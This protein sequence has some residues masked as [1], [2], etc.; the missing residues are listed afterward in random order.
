MVAAAGALLLG[1]LPAAVLGVAGVDRRGP[2]LRA[3]FPYAPILWGFVLA[4][5]CLP[6]QVYAYAWGLVTAPNGPLAPLTKMGAVLPAATNSGP[7]SGPYRIWIGSTIRAGLISAGWLWPVVA[8]ILAAGW[9]SAG[10][11][12]YALAVL[13][14]SPGKAFLRAVVPSLRAHLVAA[15]SI[16]FAITLIEYP[17][18][19]LSLARVYATEL[20]VLVDVGAPPGQVMGMG[21]QVIGIVLVLLAVAVWSVR[22]LASW[23]GLSDADEVSGSRG[24]VSWLVGVGAAMVWLLTL[25]LPVA[26]M[27]LSLRISGAWREGFKLFQ[28]EWAVSLGVSFIVALMAVAVAIA[29]AV[30]GTAVW[31]R[32]YPSSRPHPGVPGWGTLLISAPRWFMRSVPRFGAILALV[33]ALMPAAALGIGFVLIFNRAGIVG[34]LYTDTPVV[35][36]LALTARYA[37]VVVLIAWLALRKRGVEAAEQARTDGAGDWAVLSYVLLP[38][39]GPSLLAGGVIVAI[40]SLF[41]VVVSQ[42]IRP[43]GY[44]SIALALLNQMHY[45]RDDLVIITSL[46]IVTA[47]VIVTQLCGGLLV[48]R[49]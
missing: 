14:T 31:S 42:L 3:R 2:S 29:T 44:P 19:H 48:R 22:G 36:A 20:M 39:V 25:G 37:A 24:H 16:V 23:E 13:D 27:L 11:T 26:V 10:R 49:R 47:G 15:A 4:P 34:S 35:W 17:I 12:A 32:T 30:L 46:M 38:M 45:G 8:M 7:H 41:E 33:G 28:R 18:P 21:V 5:L 1:V 9:R 43:V 6:P 40:L